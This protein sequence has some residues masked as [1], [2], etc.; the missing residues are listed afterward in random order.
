MTASMASP[1]FS[2]NQAF[3]ERTDLNRTYTE[4]LL[5]SVAGRI[6]TVRSI[7]FHFSFFSTNLAITSNGMAT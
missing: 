4:R 1:F 2:F 5:L 3:S 7:F 6:F